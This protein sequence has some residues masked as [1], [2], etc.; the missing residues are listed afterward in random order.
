MTETKVD[1][2]TGEVG[3][4]AEQTIQRAR[5]Y[6]APRLKVSEKKP[7]KIEPEKRA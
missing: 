3:V 1:Y 5:I 4:A 6:G 7:G 2:D